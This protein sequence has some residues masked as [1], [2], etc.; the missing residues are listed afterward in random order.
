MMQAL[1]NSSLMKYIIIDRHWDTHIIIH[2]P[3][4]QPTE[5]MDELMN[6]TELPNTIQLSA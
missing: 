3:R 1:C 4:S 6:V 2:M 5:R